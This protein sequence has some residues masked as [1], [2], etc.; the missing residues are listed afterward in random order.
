[1]GS[2]KVIRVTK[3]HTNDE[4]PARKEFE[5]AKPLLKIEKNQGNKWHK[6]VVN[7]PFK[8]K[9]KRMNV[10]WVRLPPLGTNMFGKVSGCSENQEILDFKST[11]QPSLF[12]HF[13]VFLI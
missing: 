2:L 4:H 3:Q 6:A 7:L 12:G 11:K 13:G 1:M 5:A 8:S 10:N 9:M